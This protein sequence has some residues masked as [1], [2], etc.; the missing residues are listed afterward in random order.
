MKKHLIVT[1]FAIFAITAICINYSCNKPSTPVTTEQ[2]NMND[3]LMMDAQIDNLHLYHDS[4]VYAHMHNP[5][6]QPH[7]DSLFHHHDSIY[8]YHHNHYH[9]GDTTHHHA[10]W[11]HTPEQHYHHDSLIDAHHTIFH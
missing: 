4:T 10:G 3:A 1:S 5:P 6:H 11:H 9:H 8:N 2:E 7:Y